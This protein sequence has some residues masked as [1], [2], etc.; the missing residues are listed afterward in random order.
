MAIRTYADFFYVWLR[1]SLRPI[2]PELL[3]TMLVPKAEELVAN[4]FRHGGKEGARTFFEDG[5]QRVFERAR[6]A[7]VTDLPMTV[8]YAFKQSDSDEGGSASTGWETF[9]EGMIRTGWTITATWPSR[10]EMS[11]R[12]RSINS[13]ALA[14]S[15]VL[16]L[17]PRRA[18][19]H[20]TDRRGFIADLESQLPDA[21]RKLQQGQV[22][23]VDLPQA[24]IGPGMAVFS[25]YQRR[26]RT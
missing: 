3:S 7:A 10:S 8:W 23:P 12:T 9:L 11:N 18:G 1:R 20:T 24:A 15:I 26:S 21:L 25:G 4:P 5:F 22:A 6:E 14:S 16:A 17:R 13:N 2:Y 19:N